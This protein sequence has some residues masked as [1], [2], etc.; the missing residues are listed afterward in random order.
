[1]QIERLLIVGYGSIGKRHLKIA[2]RL[3]PFADIRV[4]R[5]QKCQSVP[6]YANGCISSLDDALAFMP[7]AAVIASPCTFHL[8]TAIPLASAG[9]HLLVEKPL[10]ASSEGITQLMAICT[11]RGSLLMTAYNMRY[12]KSLRFF[13]E[14]IF[15]EL[16]GEVI[17]VRCDIGQYLPTWRPST[18]YRKGVSASRALGGGVLLEL[19]HEIDYLRW[20]FGEVEWVNALLSKQSNLEIDVEDTAHLILGFKKNHAGRKLIGSLNMDFIRHDTKRQCLAIGESGSLRWNGV[21]GTVEYFKAGGAEWELLLRHLP[22]SEESYLS[23]WQ[24]FISSVNFG[25]VPQIS[26]ADGLAALKIIEAARLSN[27]INNRNTVTLSEDE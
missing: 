9:V 7:Q 26:G 8:Q 23:E 6:Q 18:D 10:A 2:R 17:S 5:H 4:L 21:T 11:E 16:I 13:R 24:D 3:L 14:K 27:E 19:S 15:S 22:D 20:I 12:L 1:M 25:F